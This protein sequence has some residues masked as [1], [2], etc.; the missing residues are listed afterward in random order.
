MTAL[1]AAKVPTPSERDA[2]RVTGHDLHCTWLHA[3]LVSDNLRQRGVMRLALRRGAGVDSDAAVGADPDRGA[4]IRSKAGALDEVRKADT[5]VAPFRPGG[6]L[7]GRKTGPI[8]TLQRQCLSAGIVA[9]VVEHG[10]A[11]SSDH[12]AV[13]GHLLWP[14]EVA[15][16]HLGPVQAELVRHPVHEP[17]HCEDCLWPTCAAHRCSRHLVCEEGLERQRER[18]DDVRPLKCGHGDPGQHEAP[19]DVG[20]GVMRQLPMQ[21]QDAAF[22]V[23]SQR[24]VPSLV[25]LLVRSDEVLA[26]ILNPFYRTAQELYAVRD[27]RV[28]SVERAFWTEAVIALSMQILALAR[29]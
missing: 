19:W 11:V 15:P 3:Q 29:H 20:A 26:P 28:L 1:R 9:T 6:R 14:D 8:P 5:Q 22:C 10:A 16:A 25:T 2:L 7:A 23:D 12:A 24:Q 27:Q 13:E 18:W 17:L 21:A 4:F